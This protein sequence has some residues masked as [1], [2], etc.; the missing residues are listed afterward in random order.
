VFIDGTLSNTISREVSEYISNMGRDVYINYYTSSVCP[1][2]GKDKSYG[3]SLNPMCSTCNGTGYIKHYKPLFIRGT[4]RKFVGN[5]GFLDQKHTE[6]S[7]IPSGQ[8]RFTFYL[9][10]VLVNVNSA[11]GRTYFDSCDWLKI[12]SKK[13]EV[14]DTNRFGLDQLFVIEVLVSEVKG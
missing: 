13:Y 14:K 4:F 2:G 7:V 12:D 1:Y 10:D 6:I 8:S 3:E 11:E 5:K 9:P